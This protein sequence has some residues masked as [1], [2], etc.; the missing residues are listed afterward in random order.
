MA[1]CDS[2]DILLY[3]E[4]ELGPDEAARVRAHTA[5]CDA[6]RELLLTEQALESALGGLRDL[7][8]PSDFASATV[9]RAECDVVSALHSPRERRRAAAISASLASLALLLLWPTGVY[10]SALQSLAPAR[11]LARFATGW[12]HNT[13]LSAFIVCRTLSRNLLEESSLSVGAVLA[14]LLLL[15]S[16]LAWLIAGYRREMAERGRHTAQ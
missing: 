6:C 13:A 14:V 1:C 3:I 15:V 7:E 9:R 8:P 4:G 2:Q 10:G 11:C 5:V 12:I 16:L